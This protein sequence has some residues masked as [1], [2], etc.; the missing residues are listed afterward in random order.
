MNT[1][2]R[3]HPDE[4]L[5]TQESYWSQSNRS[6]FRKVKEDWNISVD[7][8]F[9]RWI[10]AFATLE[11]KTVRLLISL[12]DM[13]MLDAFWQ[14][15]EVNS[16][17][18]IIVVNGGFTFLTWPRRFTIL[19]QI[20]RNDETRS[21]S[22]CWGFVLWKNTRNWDRIIASTSLSLRHRINRYTHY[23][24]TELFLERHL[25]PTEH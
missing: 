25:Y 24:P 5:E 4:H 12:A 8:L 22:G 7:R 11:T 23:F 16:S 20:P 1:T 15:T 17:P 14:T 9:T 13:V 19:V 3:D 10:E 18:G 2:A 6:N 21:W